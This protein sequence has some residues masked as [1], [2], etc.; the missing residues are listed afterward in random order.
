MNWQPR[1][2][3]NPNLRL[4]RATVLETA[5]LTI[6]PRGSIEFFKFPRHFFLVLV[7]Q[8]NQER[9]CCFVSLYKYY[10]IFFLKNQFKI[11]QHKSQIHHNPY[12]R[13]AY[14]QRVYSF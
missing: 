3:S 12:Q 9:F 14:I 2:D 11:L 8:T 6:T 7:L 13:Y 4:Q 1:R 10:I 5:V